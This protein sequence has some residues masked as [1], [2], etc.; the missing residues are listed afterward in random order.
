MM[1]V[2]KYSDRIDINDFIE[3]GGE[4]LYQTENGKDAFDW[5]VKYYVS[6]GD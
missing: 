2:V 5:L 6:I 1:Y 3:E 4:L